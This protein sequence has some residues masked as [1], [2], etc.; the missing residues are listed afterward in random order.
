MNRLDVLVE[1]VEL[2]KP[3]AEIADNISKLEWDYDGEPLII[4]SNQVKNIIERYLSGVLS[5]R[6]LEEWANLI[7]CREDIDFEESNR[8]EIEY[9]IYSLSNPELEGDISVES[10]KSLLATLT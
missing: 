3:I 6:E 5:N 2:R 7:E 1:L 4:S 9:I 8:N 10:C